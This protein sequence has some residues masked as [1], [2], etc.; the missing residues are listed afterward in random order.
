M[1]TLGIV[2]TVASAFVIFLL[3]SMFSGMLRALLLGISAGVLITA[4]QSTSVAQGILGRL[5]GG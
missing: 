3:A 2:A 1:R 5:G 4:I